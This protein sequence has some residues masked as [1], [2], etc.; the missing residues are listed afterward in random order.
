MGVVYEAYDHQ[1]D[2]RVAF[3]RLATLTPTALYRLKREFRAVADLHHPNI[4]ALYDLVN[5]NGE[6][7]FTMEVVDGVDLLTWIGVP[8]VRELRSK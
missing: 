7:G 4:V 6:W 8:V 5:E 1:R 2:A 3:K